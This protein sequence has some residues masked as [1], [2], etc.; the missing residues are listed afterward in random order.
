MDVEK[1]IEFIMDHQ[2]QAED[3]M[4]RLERPAST[5]IAWDP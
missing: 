1:R 2:A 5:H 3:R 4:E